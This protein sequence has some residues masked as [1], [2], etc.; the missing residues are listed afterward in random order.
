MH[1]WATGRHSPGRVASRARAL[2]TEHETL[3][4]SARAR[5]FRT[6]PCR[7]CRERRPSGDLLGPLGEPGADHGVAGDQLREALLAPT[8][9]AGWPHGQHEK[10]GFRRRI[11]HANLGVR[12]QLDAEIGEH[13]PRVLDRARAVGRG[14]VPNRRQAEHLPRI[15]GAQG[16]YDH[17]VE[18]GR[19]LDGNQMVA[20]PALVTERAHRL[21]AVV[22]QR[23][24]ERGIA[25]GLGNDARAGVGADLGLVG[26]DDEI[27]RSRIDIALL[28]QDRLQRAHAQLRLG[29]LG[30]VLV[31][32][33]LG[34]GNLRCSIGRMMQYPPHNID[35]VRLSR[36][37]RRPT[38]NH[39]YGAAAG[40]LQCSLVIVMWIV[41]WVGAPLQPTSRLAFCC[42]GPIYSAML[43]PAPYLSQKLTRPL[44][45]KDGG[46]LRTLTAIDLCCVA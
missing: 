33:V 26:L 36:E 6:R 32:V 31:V 25:P 46:T 19:V 15:A 3:A 22:E 8:L 4:R 30:A 5:P 44:G 39:T 37:P 27:E 20:D 2:P 9:G 10:A 13:A 40:T 41:M 12:R 7:P 24:L 45:T 17:V 35:L 34:H 43:G 23:P 42:R 18:R 28:G 38:N 14:F 1:R 29:E 21:G 16:A 11:P